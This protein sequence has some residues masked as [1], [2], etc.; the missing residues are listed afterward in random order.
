MQAKEQEL[1]RALQAEQLRAVSL[2]TQLANAQEQVRQ[3]EAQL[4]GEHAQRMELERTVQVLTM[5]AETGMAS[6]GP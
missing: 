1:E 2:E 3:L 4:Q 6:G 5:R